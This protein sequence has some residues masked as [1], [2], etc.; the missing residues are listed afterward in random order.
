MRVISERLGHASMAMKMDKYG[1]LFPN[2]HDEAAG[3]I[4]AALRAAM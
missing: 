2:A 3:A 4:D 1:Y